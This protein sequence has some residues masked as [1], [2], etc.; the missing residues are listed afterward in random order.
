V[1]LIGVLA[2]WAA[3]FRRQILAAISIVA[4]TLFVC[5]A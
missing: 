4:G 5:D 2:A 1:A 3:R